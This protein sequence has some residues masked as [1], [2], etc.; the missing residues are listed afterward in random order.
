MAMTAHNLWIDFIELQQMNGDSIHFCKKLSIQLMPD[1]ASRIFVSK[2][3]DQD[4]DH[5]AN[6]SVKIFKY[7]TT[8]YT[9][10]L[11]LIKLMIYLFI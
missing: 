11:D 6:G 4:L 3:S 10:A 2:F 5:I 8:N 7:F 1:I 9:S